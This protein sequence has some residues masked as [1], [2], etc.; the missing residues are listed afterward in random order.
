[1]KTNYFLNTVILSLFLICYGVTD[2]NAQKKTR[3]R[4]KVYYE[5]LTNNDKKISFI[6]NQGSG[7]K[8]AGIQEAVI[9]LTTYDLENEIELT[10]VNTDS[11]G[12]A[13]F[14]IEANYP[15]PKDV[16][17]YSVISARYTGNDSLKAA[18]K[19]IKFLDLNITISFEIIDSVKLLTVS[20]FGIDS[21]GSN[22]PVED[23]ELNIGV[24]RLHSTLY[25]EKIKTNEKGIA[26]MEFPG[27]I[28]GDSIGI[29]NVIVR[30]NEHDD[31][32]TIVKSAR[33]NWGTIVDY[34]NTSYGRSLFSDEAPLWMIIS[35]FIILSGAWYHFIL[36]IFKVIKIR[37]V[38]QKII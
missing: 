4:L 26:S 23:I 12:E 13:I 21:L 16:D 36:A 29:I 8:I 31:Y 22:K 17:G 6:L 14:L 9:Y 18:K 32:G 5:K 37:D 7:K 11:N 35:V 30:L 3:T 1:M 25:L 2:T 20:T 10:S 24:E 38:E 27:D 33:T 28:P 15:F 34:S 19:L